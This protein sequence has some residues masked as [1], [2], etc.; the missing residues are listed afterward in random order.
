MRNKFLIIATLLSFLFM[1]AVIAFG[2]KTMSGMAKGETLQIPSVTMLTAYGR[3]ALAAA[4]DFAS[5][6]LRTF[7][8]NIDGSNAADEV[9]RHI[10][11]AG[12]A[13]EEAIGKIG[14]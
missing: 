2:F 4:T 9:T 14:R 8:I 12:A 6:V 10:E 11:Q 13:V 5:P 7:G 1:A 3:K